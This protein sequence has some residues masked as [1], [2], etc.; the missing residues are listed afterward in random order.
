MLCHP[1]G[2]FGG[3]PTLAHGPSRCDLLDLRLRRP[4]PKLFRGDVFFSCGAIPGIGGL[5]ISRIFAPVLARM[6]WPALM[7]KIFGSSAVPRKFAGILKEMA[8]RP[9]QLRA[10]VHVSAY[11]L[12]RLSVA[13]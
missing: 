9:S 12:C 1:W 6:M 3:D 5:H 7:K 11:D 13:Q 8:L 2:A 4:H 10:S